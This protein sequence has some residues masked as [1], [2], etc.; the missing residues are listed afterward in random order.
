ME[1]DRGLA[2]AIITIVLNP[3]GGFLGEDDVVVLGVFG[4]NWGLLLI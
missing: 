4:S 3:L 1:L 2:L